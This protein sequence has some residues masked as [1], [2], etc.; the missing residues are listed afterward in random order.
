MAKKTPPKAVKK[1][2]RTPNDELETS[3]KV[4]EF[5]ESFKSIG[6]NVMLHSDNGDIHLIGVDRIA[7]Y[8][9]GKGELPE[10]VKRALVNHWFAE[11][12]YPDWLEYFA[13]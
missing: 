9:S 12:R 8:V 5:A 10:A 11:C 7:A 2:K 13:E 6:P 4:V 1:T 3:G